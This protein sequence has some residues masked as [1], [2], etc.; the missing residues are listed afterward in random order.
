MKPIAVLLAV[1]CAASAQD[2][3]P[4]A[5]AFPPVGDK[6]AAEDKDFLTAELQK[7]QAEFDMLP[8]KKENANAEIFLKAVRYAIDYS[9]FYKPEDGGR[10]KGLRACLRRRRRTPN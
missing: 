1:C 7:V 5:R 9:E 6:L 4:P 2:L 10:A 8:K 3:K